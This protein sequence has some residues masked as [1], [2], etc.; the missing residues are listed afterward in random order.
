[1][2]TCRPIPL[3]VE[4]CA[5][6]AAVSLR[7][8]Q[9]KARPPVSRMGAK[10][11]YAD[12]ILYHLHLQP[13][14]G[15]ES[16]LWCDPDPGV[17]LMLEAYRDP[18]LAR[19]AADVIRSW[20]DEDPR[21]LWDRLRAE[22]AL[23]GVTG[24]EVARLAV[25]DAGAHPGGG[26]FRGL[27]IRRPSVDGFIPSSLEISRR[28]A[29]LLW[30]QRRSAHGKGGDYREPN[31]TH[32][33]APDAPADQVDALP[34]LGATI[35]PAAIPPQANARGAVVYID[36]PYQNT[37]GYAHDLPRAEVER[38]A[39]AWAE[40]GATVAIS[41]AEPI[42]LPGWEHVEITGERKG[43]KRTFSRQQSEWLTIW[44]A[45]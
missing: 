40:A 16:Y 41:E 20:A 27:H 42:A 6:T 39:L 15:A 11:G 14:Q 33:I 26:G 1:M 38:L 32:R 31:E 18:A 4:L 2:L 29:A 35:Y 36:P 10:T 5:G 43:Q 37:T 8:A 13:G 25:V 24:R 21:A 3:F 12:A 17:R 44:R 34:M 45:P 7:L 19:E 28:L 23:S 22:G 9:P 30:T